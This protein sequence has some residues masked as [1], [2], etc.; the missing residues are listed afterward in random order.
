MRSPRCDGYHC[1]SAIAFDDHDGQ[2]YAIDE[3][4][5]EVVRIS[6]RG[7][8]VP[9]A[10]AYYVAFP[11]SEAPCVRRDGRGPA[12]RFCNPSGL[13]F[14]R[15]TNSF[16]IADTDNDAVRRVTPDGEVST[17]A[18]GD[19]KLCSHFLYSE[20]HVCKPRT[21]AINPKRSDIYVIQGSAI[22]RINRAGVQVLAG[23]DPLGWSVAGCAGRDGSGRSAIYCH[24]DGLA[25]APQGSA[26]YVSEQDSDVVH[27]ITLDGTSTVFSG[28]RLANPSGFFPPF[29]PALP[30]WLQFLKYYPCSMI[31]G[32]RAAA[33]YCEP[34]DLGMDDL[35]NTLY[36]AD[37]RSIRA[38]NSSGDVSTVVAPSYSE[39]CVPADGNAQRA[40]V[41]G[42]QSLTLDQRGRA[43]YTLD[44]DSAIR[45][46]TIP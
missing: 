11:Q 10:G 31:D 21:V 3:A 12:A 2:L 25:V 16:L 42:S 27:R 20:S 45:R 9:I 4:S 26:L 46:V 22:M 24:L 19:Q 40:R 36:V 44:E 41:C 37:V 35:T 32:V 17:V 39:E 30:H 1:I 43:L 29:I 5:Q 18:F 13:A 33:T 28:Q 34:T 8:E 6:T 23:A 14:D 15:A 38:D 7:D